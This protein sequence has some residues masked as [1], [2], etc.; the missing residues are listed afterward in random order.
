MNCTIDAK[1]KS[2]LW[3]RFAAGLAIS[4]FLVLW[5][6]VM[7]ARAQPHGGGGH[8]AWHGGGYDGRRGYGHGGGGGYYRPPPVVYGSSYGNS[9]YGSPYNP[10]PVVY[11]PGISIG[12][13]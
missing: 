2:G 5:A 4:T 10:P 6:P 8:Q 13:W 1:P 12:I 11:V 9:Y 7:S 3:M